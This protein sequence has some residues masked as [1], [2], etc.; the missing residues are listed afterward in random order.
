MSKE[1]NSRILRREKQRTENVGRAAK[2]SLARAVELNSERQLYEL[3]DSLFVG[4]S[5]WYYWEWRDSFYAQIP[6]QSWFEHYAS[7]FNTVELNA[8]FYSWP[9]VARIRSWVRQADP[10]EFVYCVKVPE[11]VTH[12]KK[13]DGTEA[14]I[15]DF[16][17]VAEI[18]GSRFGCFLYQM[19]PSFHY[20]RSRLEGIIKQLRPS[21]RNVVEF[22]HPSWWNDE[23]Y[24]AFN[25]ASIIFCSC[26]A[27]GLPAKLIRTADDVYV[28]MHGPKVW[29]KYKYSVDELRWWSEEI[30]RSGAKRAWVYFNN[31]YYANAPTDARAM[32]WMLEGF[33]RE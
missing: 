28:R 19:P 22:R 12:I 17:A 10:K 15:E 7:I 8:S 1:E 9:T 27:P 5:G 33:G 18:L 2:M 16:D 31:T 29:Y 26:S 23:V 32:Q 24:S 11:L 20:S 3:S 13:L 25:N 6:R 4:C 21:R 14:L 30:R